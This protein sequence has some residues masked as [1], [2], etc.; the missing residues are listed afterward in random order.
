MIAVMCYLF[1]SSCSNCGN[2]RTISL[3]SMRGIDVDGDKI[4]VFPENADTR[5]RSI[6]ANITCVNRRT[7]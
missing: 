7:S 5:E 4:Y 6:N 1:L 3:A 2:V